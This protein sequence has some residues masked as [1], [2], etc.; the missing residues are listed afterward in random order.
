MER[1]ISVGILRPNYVVIPNIPVRRNR[2][3]PFHLN[4]NRNF[5]NLWHNG[6][7]PKGPNPNWFRSVS[8]LKNGSFTTCSVCLHGTSLVPSTTESKRAK[9]CFTYTQNKKSRIGS[10]WYGSCVNTR[11][12]AAG[13]KTDWSGGYSTFTGPFTGP[14]TR[15]DFVAYDKLTK[16]LRHDLFLVNQTYNSLVIVL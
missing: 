10:L 11:K 15:Y 16:G 3:V 7:H 8:L 13:P 2:K 4:S 1:R 12:C 9:N 14:F 6:K 5:R